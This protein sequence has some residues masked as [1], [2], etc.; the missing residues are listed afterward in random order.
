MRL[1]EPGWYNGGTACSHEFAVKEFN[2]D[3]SEC[4]RAETVCSESVEP[5]G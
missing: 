3:L 1:D 5:V 2:Q 4:H